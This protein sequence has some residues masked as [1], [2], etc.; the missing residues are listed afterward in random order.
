M[1]GV[2]DR[3]QTTAT[4]G[5]TMDNATRSEIKDILQECRND[6]RRVRQYFSRLPELL[7]AVAEALPKRG[8]WAVAVVVDFLV[9]HRAGC[10]MHKQIDPN[11]PSRPHTFAGLVRRDQW[12]VAKSICERLCREGRAERATGLGD[13]GREAITF[14][15]VY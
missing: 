3:Q 13:N 14:N 6:A 10:R 2:G 5:N 15:G 11:W 4:K 9:Q 7:D 8:D 1:S 12:R